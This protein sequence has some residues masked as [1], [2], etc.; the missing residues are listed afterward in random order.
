LV[1]ARAQAV[2]ADGEA[3]MLENDARR[4]AIEAKRLY[5]VA[6]DI[7]RRTYGP[8]RSSEEVNAERAK[9]WLWWPM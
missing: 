2:I 1:E 4:A 3:T 9:Q 5:E 8:G 7:G 6:D